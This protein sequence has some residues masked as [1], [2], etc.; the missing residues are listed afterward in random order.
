MCTYVNVHVTYL[1]LT[2]TRP[3]PLPCPEHTHTTQ[4]IHVHRQTVQLLHCTFVSDRR[5]ATFIK[6]L[7]RDII[8]KIL[9]F[10]FR[11]KASEMCCGQHN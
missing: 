6:L 3:L 4:A 8:V 11:I 7:K 10:D 2:Y 9:H 1:L 5:P